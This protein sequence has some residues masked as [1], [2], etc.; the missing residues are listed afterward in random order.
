MRVTLQTG[1]PT[2]PRCQAG[3][4]GGSRCGVIAGLTPCAANEPGLGRAGGEADLAGSGGRM[5]LHR[6][7]PRYLS[8]AC[9]QGQS[10]GSL[11]MRPL[12]PI[13]TACQALV[14]EKREVDPGSGRAVV[15]VRRVVFLDVEGKHHL[16]RMGFFDRVWIV[17]GQSQKSRLKRLAAADGSRSRVGAHPPAEVNAAT[18]V[19]GQ[20]VGQMNSD[21]LMTGRARGPM[22]GQKQ[23]CGSGT[24]WTAARRPRKAAV[25]DSGF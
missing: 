6:S 4:P 2:A 11:H 22:S 21:L 10:S 23:G 17:V 5:V 24:T 13:G 14:R 25:T 9:I 3:R 18:S 12:P 7:T 19:L 15:W 20:T 16:H 8:S 1:T